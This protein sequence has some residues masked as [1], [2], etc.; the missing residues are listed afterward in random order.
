VLLPDLSRLPDADIL[1]GNLDVVVSLAGL[2]DFDYSQ[3][4]LADLRRSAW[5]AY[6]MD[7]AA[8]RYAR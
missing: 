1:P 7:R 6:A 2:P 4:D 8:T 5:P 3:L